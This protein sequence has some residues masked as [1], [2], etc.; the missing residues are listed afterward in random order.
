MADTFIRRSFM[1][2][3]DG[4]RHSRT[5]IKERVAVGY[6][7]V[8]LAAFHSTGPGWPRRMNEALRDGLTRGGC[9]KA[10]KTIHRELTSL[11]AQIKAVAH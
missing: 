3:I 10:W 1:A 11:H 7:P 8:L 9:R 2:K 6:S 5:P 4:L